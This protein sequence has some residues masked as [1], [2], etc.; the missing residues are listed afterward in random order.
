MDKKSK[1]ERDAEALLERVRSAKILGH[2]RKLIL[3]YYNE[4]TVTGTKPWSMIFSLRILL[5]L[6][7]KFRKRQFKDLKKRDLQRFFVE[8]KPLPHNWTGKAEAEYSPRTMWSFMSS[9]KTF[10]K[11]LYGLDDDDA[12]PDSV[13]WIKRKNICS[14]DSVRKRPIEVLSRDEVLEMIKVARNERDKALIAVLF[15]TGMRAKE[16]LS[17]RRQDIQHG[18]GFATFK[19]VG[20]GGK[21]RQVLIEWSY[22]YLTEWLNW[23]DGHERNVLKEHRGFVWIAFP[24]RSMK[25]Y[26]T[27]SSGHLMDR[28]VLRTNIVNIAKRAGI[29]KRVWTHGFRHSSATDFARQGYNETELRLKYGWSPTS[30]IPSNYTHYNFEQLKKKILVKSGK[31]KEKDEFA[32]NVLGSK[33]CLYCGF[34]NSGQSKYCNGCGNPLNFQKPVERREEKGLE[35]MQAT[36][37]RFKELEEKGID[38]Q[39]FNRFMESWV[40]NSEKS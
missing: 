12:F 40:K 8:M 10:W 37:E 31:S 15:E 18:D 26:I 7:E 30:N 14:S 23:L 4:K 2:N 19:V 17:M 22:P 24:C 28:E 21:E 36:L 38:L 16:L 3:D 9:L 27:G 13:K 6:A 32:K 29:K 1:G 33:K 20:K 34:E 39:Q 5:L 25:R 11:W 35:L